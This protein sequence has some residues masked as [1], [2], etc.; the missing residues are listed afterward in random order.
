LVQI[1]ESKHKKQR[2]QKSEQANHYLIK[3]LMEKDEEKCPLKNHNQI[4]VEHIKK[5]KNEKKLSK[6]YEESYHLRILNQQLLSEIKTLKNEITE[7]LES[8]NE[9][10]K[11]QNK[12]KLLCLRRHNQELPSQ[13]RNLKHPK[14][15]L[16]LEL[17]H[18]ETMTKSVE[19]ERLLVQK[20]QTLEKETNIDPIEL[21][22][23]SKVEKRSNKEYS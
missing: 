12:E 17:D 3:K 8:K 16:Q 11:S 9:D 18:K 7:N 15:S 10:D 4:L 14:K 1:N 2:D 13:I 20:I 19:I 21:P 6:K 22:E 23:T 5:L